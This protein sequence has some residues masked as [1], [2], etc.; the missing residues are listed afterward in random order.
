MEGKPEIIVTW[1]KLLPHEQQLIVGLYNIR[2]SPVE[3]ESFAQG[4]MNAQLWSH[5]EIWNPADGFTEIGDSREDAEEIAVWDA[6]ASITPN[7]ELQLSGWSGPSGHLPM[8]T[9][10]M[11]FSVKIRINTWVQERQR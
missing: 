3:G 11:P 10:I 2:C 6:S 8:R 5:A 4:G 7:G 9:E 1:D